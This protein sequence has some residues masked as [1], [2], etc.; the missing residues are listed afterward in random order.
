MRKCIFTI[1]ILVVF[2]SF[3]QGFVYDKDGY[4]NVRNNYVFKESQVVDT[5]HN[6]HLVWI[7]DEVDDWFEVWSL[8]NEKRNGFVH[9][10]RIIQLYQKNNFEFSKESTD[11]LLVRGDKITL[12]IERQ[13]ANINNYSISDSFGTDGFMPKYQYKEIL[14]VFNQ[15]KIVLTN[16]DHLK[17]LYE[18][19]VNHINIYFNGYYK[20]LYLSS[21]NGDGAGA[22]IVIWIIDEFENVE[23]ITTIPF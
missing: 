19:N 17:N 4:V 6:N 21:L 18:P 13:K 9:K 12:E 23:R 11:K 8:R 1:F 14:I 2:N 7:Q 20:K 15:K 22:Y 16:E 5:L 10:S 3:S